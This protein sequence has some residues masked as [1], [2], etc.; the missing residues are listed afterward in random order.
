VSVYQAVTPGGAVLYHVGP[1]LLHL[2][3]TTTWSDGMVHSAIV[4]EDGSVLTDQAWPVQA[5][6]R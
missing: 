5:P 2:T 6:V 3:A 4:A 1:P